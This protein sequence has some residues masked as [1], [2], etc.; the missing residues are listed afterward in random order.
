MGILLSTTICVCVRCH[1]NEL[2]F[3]L[4]INA[5]F[6]KINSSVH[7]VK[8]L[9]NIFVLEFFY[10]GP[11]PSTSECRSLSVSSMWFYLEKCVSSFSV[12]LVGCHLA[13]TFGILLFLSLF[14]GRHCMILLFFVQHKV[15]SI[16]FNSILSFRM[17]T[18]SSAKRRWFRW[19]LS[20][21]IHL[22][23]Q[24]GCLKLFR[25]MVLPWCTP[26]TILIDNYLHCGILADMLY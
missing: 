6:Q 23:S 20:I 12:L 14:I 21:L 2:S 10:F 26:F 19:V 15:P 1:K 18:K 3:F 9:I 17:M 16:F 5:H 24:C 22:Y 7:V 11:Y 25:R 8:F 4:Y 13:I